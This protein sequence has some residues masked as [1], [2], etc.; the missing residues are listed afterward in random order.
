MNGRIARHLDRLL[1]MRCNLDRRT[2]A[3]LIAEEAVDAALAGDLMAIRL[4]LDAEASFDP[5][6]DSLDPDESEE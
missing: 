4:I 3:E 1:A 2:V 6:I 5:S